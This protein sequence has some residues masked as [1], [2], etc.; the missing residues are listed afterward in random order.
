MVLSTLNNVTDE[1]RV[2]VLR[3]S[4]MTEERKVIAS[5][6]AVVERAC[7]TGVHEGPWKPGLRARGITSQKKVDA[8]DGVCC[9]LCSKA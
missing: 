2:I 9:G 4:R 1:R 7:T 3:R 8:V 6:R 5:R